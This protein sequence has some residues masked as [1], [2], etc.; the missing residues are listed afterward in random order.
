MVDLGLVRA[1]MVVPEDLEEGP[2]E[3]AGVQLVVVAAGQDP[4]ELGV[5]QAE[6][7]EETLVAQV[8]AE[9]EFS[10]QSL[11]GAVA[12]ERVAV[13]LLACAHPVEVEEDDARV[14]AL[15]AAGRAEWRV[16]ML[17]PEK[18]QHEHVVGGEVDGER[19]D[20]KRKKPGKNE[21]F[22]RKENRREMAPG[23][24]MKMDGS[25]R[26]PDNRTFPRY[27]CHIS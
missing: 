20:W 7:G 24:L 23:T 21:A 13:V 3:H 2:A 22:K 19:H 10:R 11:D 9:F 1:V 8:R 16:R 6:Q 18:P 4:E 15:E 26:C 12:V 14:E 5:L 27:S 17:L 25:L